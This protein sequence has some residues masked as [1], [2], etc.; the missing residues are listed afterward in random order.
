MD[1]RILRAVGSLSGMQD[2]KETVTTLLLASKYHQVQSRSWV[3]ASIIVFSGTGRPRSDLK[4][5][6]AFQIRDFLK[7]SIKT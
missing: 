1:G 6:D 5:I 3:I 2:R 7:L 4:D